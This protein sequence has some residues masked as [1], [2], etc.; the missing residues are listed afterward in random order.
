MKKKLDIKLT[1]DDISSKISFLLQKSIL[2]NKSTSKGDFF[3]F[4]KNVDNIVKVVRV[5]E[6]IVKSVDE[7]VDFNGEYIAS[8]ENSYLTAYPN[9]TE[10]GNMEGNIA[11]I[12]AELRALKSFVTG[13]LYSLSGIWIESGQTTEY[14]QSEILEKN[15]NL[16]GKIQVRI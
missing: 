11:F 14:G 6:D 12:K 2:S 4:T 8:P 3:Y 9:S 1:E 7:N 10:S 5:V 16:R 13:E 15:A